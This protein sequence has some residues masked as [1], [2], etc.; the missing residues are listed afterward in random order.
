MRTEYCPALKPPKKGMMAISKWQK[1]PGKSST[2]DPP[3]AFSL[4]V[5]RKQLHRVSDLSRFSLGMFRENHTEREKTRRTNALLVSC[6][7]EKD[8]ANHPRLERKTATDSEKVAET[9]R[10]LRSPCSRRVYTGTAQ[11][12]HDRRSAQGCTQHKW[13]NPPAFWN[14]LPTNIHSANRTGK[15][16][17]QPHR[18]VC[19]ATEIALSRNRIHVG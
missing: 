3:A 10:F 17:E 9:D 7:P 6:A 12:R 15:A 1:R 4:G 11:E 18:A 16:P 13:S 2:C 14:S 5:A 19:S 8:T